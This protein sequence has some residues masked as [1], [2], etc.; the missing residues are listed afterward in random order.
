MH[1]TWQT[2]PCFTLAA[3]T[4]RVTVTSYTMQE[5]S[6]P[7][8]ESQPVKMILMPNA[9]RAVIV[10]VQKCLSLT[11]TLLHRQF[12]WLSLDDIQ[13]KSESF[14]RYCIQ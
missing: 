13:Y 7:G 8:P 11:K 5:S 14:A 3:Q 9:A 4:K 1:K 6:A 12:L 2:Q 10:I